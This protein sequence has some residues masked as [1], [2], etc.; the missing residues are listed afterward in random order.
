MA[1]IM[2]KYHTVRILPR[3]YS[4]SGGEAKS[5][6]FGG[7]F[8]LRLQLRNEEGKGVITMARKHPHMMTLQFISPGLAMVMYSKSVQHDNI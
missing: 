6:R 3:Y 4:V 8:C 5:M 2:A 7:W 1:V